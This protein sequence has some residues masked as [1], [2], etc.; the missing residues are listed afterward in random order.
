ME[1]NPY[2]STLLG[3]QPQPTEP[4]PRRLAPTLLGCLVVIVTLGVLAALLLPATRRAGPAAYRMQCSINLKQIAIAL[5][6]Y[7]DK[8]GAL[9]PAYTVDADGKPLH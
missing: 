6:S 9:P 4:K 8:Y 2:Q 5:H 3:G 1:V 7:H